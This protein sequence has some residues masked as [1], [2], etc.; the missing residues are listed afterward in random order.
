[1]VRSK[2]L[3]LLTAISLGAA[4]TAFANE[5]KITKGFYTMDAMGCMLLR[6]CTEDVQEL[7]SI[8]DIKNYYPDS[9]FSAIDSEFNSIIRALNAVG[10]KVFLGAERYFPAGHR[11]VYHTVSNN[12][13]LNER[14]MHRQGVLMSVMRHEGW[15]AAQDCMAGSIENSLIA[16]IKPEEEVPPIWRELAERTYPPS[17]VPWEAEASWAG[18]TEDMTAKALEAC[19]TGAMWEVYEPTPLTEQWLIENEYIK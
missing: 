11:G 6:E 1:M 17:A 14:F 18:R 4:P 19:A 13:F 10:V 3:A 2:I 15:H 12:F 9:D 7:T 5:D 8:Q 16:I